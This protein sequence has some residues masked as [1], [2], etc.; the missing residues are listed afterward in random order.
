M[1]HNLL[2]LTLIISPLMLSL[3][4]HAQT[5]NYQQYQQPQQNSPTH[6]PHYQTP[7]PMTEDVL[8][9]RFDIQLKITK[10]QMAFDKRQADAYAANFARY[11]KQQADDLH[12][13]MAQA[14]KQ[15]Q[16]TIKRLESQQ[17][18]FLTQ[19]SKYQQTNDSKK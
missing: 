2:S 9:K 13:M 4:A 15:R 16:F 7:K 12:K 11:Q 1:K 3:S 6:I 14:E 17:Q 10:Q 19:F 18:Y 5:S 8:K